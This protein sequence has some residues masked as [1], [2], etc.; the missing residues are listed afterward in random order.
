ML[1]KFTSTDMF[2]TSLVNVATGKCAYEIT[3]VSTPCQPERLPPPPLFSSSNTT[4]ASE[5]SDAAKRYPAAREKPKR[6][7]PH[8]RTQIRDG[9]GHLAADVQWEGRHPHITIDGEEIGGLNDL[10]GSSTVRFL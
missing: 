1:L 6:D 4:S 7:V 3:T 8:R 9:S 10:F 5:D 2:N